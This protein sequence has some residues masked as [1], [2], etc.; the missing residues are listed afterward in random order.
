MA[1][2]ERLN[3]PYIYANRSLIERASMVVLDANLATTPL[4]P[5]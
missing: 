4:A 1:C 5:L 3:P 2:L